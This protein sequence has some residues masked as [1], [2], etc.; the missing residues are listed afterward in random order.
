MQ[1]VKLQRE[2]SRGILTRD[3]KPLV[4]LIENTSD[5][6]GDERLGVYENNFFASIVAVMAT[7]FPTV[8]NLVGQGYFKNLAR[9]FVQ[10]HPPHSGC[11]HEYGDLFPNFIKHY[12]AL[13]NY[14][15]L[16]DVAALDWARHVVYN[17]QDARPLPQDDF[18]ALQDTDLNHVTFAFLPAL[19]VM[20]SNYPLEQ[21]WQ[22]VYEGRQ[23]LVDMNVGGAYVLVC[24]PHYDIQQYWLDEIAFHL[25]TGLRTGRSLGHM[26][27]ALASAGKDILQKAFAFMITSKIIIEIK[28]RNTHD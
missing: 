13:D 8:E 27:E 19:Q 28:G 7:T 25:I 12:K 22:L 1:T 15:Y 11:L 10:S 26:F 2:F 24:R 20:A 4:G 21:I 16:S 18:Q 14:P 5:I 23:E 17:A 9:L 6:P 3:M